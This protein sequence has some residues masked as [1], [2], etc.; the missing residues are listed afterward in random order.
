MS[1]CR[2]HTVRYLP[3]VARPAVGSG[4]RLEGAYPRST[5]LPTSGQDPG[6]G[7]PRSQGRAR[8]TLESLRR[9]SFR[10]PTRRVAAKTSGRLFGYATG[11]KIDDPRLGLPIAI[12]PVIGDH[13]YRNDGAD[14]ECAGK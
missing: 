8:S 3:R 14:P 12:Q 10:S 4:P 13:S 11:Q 5:R 9:S 6:G 2:A 1:G 7:K